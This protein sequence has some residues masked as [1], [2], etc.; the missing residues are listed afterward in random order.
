MQYAVNKQKSRVAKVSKA[1]LDAVMVERKAQDMVSFKEIRESLSK[2]GLKDGEIHQA[3][4]DA[5]YEVQG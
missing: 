2:P 3:L 1:Q 5:G 4:L